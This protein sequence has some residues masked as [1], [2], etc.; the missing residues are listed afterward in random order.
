MTGNLASLAVP[1]SWTRGE[2]STISMMGCFEQAVKNEGNQL[3]YRTI[4]I[5]GQFIKRT[6]QRIYNA[7]GSVR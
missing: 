7:N 3:K 6:F 5:S 2:T 4:Q 1:G